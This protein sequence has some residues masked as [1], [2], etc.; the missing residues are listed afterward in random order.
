MYMNLSDYINSKSQND[1]ELKSFFKKKES[2]VIFDIGSCEG[3]DSIRYKRMFPYATIYSFEPLPTNV[4]KMKRNLERYKL[5]GEISIIPVALT[6]HD[7]IADFFVSSGAPP[8]KEN[9]QEWNYGNKSSSLLQ[10]T[11]I[12]KKYYAWLDFKERIEINVQR[13]DSFCQSKKI[14]RIDF[15]HL[16]VQG[17]E[18]KVLNGA[19]SLINTIKAVWLEVGSVE[20]YKSQPLKHDIEIFMQHHGFIKVTDTVSDVTGDQFYVNRK[21]ISQVTLL[22]Y[23]INANLVPF[24]KIKIKKLAM[25]FFR[26]LPDRIRKVYYQK[27]NRLQ[28]NRI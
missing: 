18:L 8:E 4:I 23:R 1:L 10:P 25:P 5:V 27:V 20:L 15:I 6:D 28:N 9:S 11:D 12:S 21:M 3:E 2:L 19:S 13:L 14:T 7:G 22:R 17:A 26:I 24:L 16:D